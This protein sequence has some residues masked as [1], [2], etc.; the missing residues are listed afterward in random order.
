MI[1]ELVGKFCQGEL[2]RC[3]VDEKESG[4]AFWGSVE[5]RGIYG[6]VETSGVTN[7]KA[8]FDIWCCIIVS[9]PKHTD[10]NNV[11]PCVTENPMCRKK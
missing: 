11:H 4:I 5:G 8:K 9:F 3:G 10:L 1:V 6:G 2:V 7:A